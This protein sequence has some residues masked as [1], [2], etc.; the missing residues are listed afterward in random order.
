V[1]NLG[2]GFGA[3]TRHYARRCW[4]P[5]FL[6]WPLMLVLF[7]LTFFAGVIALA[8]MQKSTFQGLG[9]FL[10]GPLRDDLRFTRRADR[11]RS[12]RRISLTLH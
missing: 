12:D 1:R 4:L 11:C 8:L 6:L 10:S 7:G 5:V 9:R 2:P 3:G